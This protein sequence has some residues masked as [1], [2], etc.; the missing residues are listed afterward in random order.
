LIPE[1]HRISHL[2][3]VFTLERG[4]FLGGLLLLLGL[5]GSA[6]GF[7]YWGTRMF[8]QL[9]PFVMMRIII[10]S[11]TALTVG[12]QIVLSSFFLSALQLKHR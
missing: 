12:F 10:P 4:I 7:I 8:G 11:L 5:T 6:Y 2:L 3:R 9:N 1:D